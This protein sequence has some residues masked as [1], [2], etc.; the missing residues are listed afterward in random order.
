MINM[1]W[2]WIGLI[3]SIASLILLII[4]WWPER[5]NQWNKVVLSLG[6]IIIIIP[7]AVLYFSVK[8]QLNLKN[9]LKFAEDKLNYAEIAKQNYLGVTDTVGNGLTEESFQSKT[10]GPFVSV[11][12]DHVPAWRCSDSA[13]EA[14]DK[15]IREVPK[16][17]FTYYYRGTCERANNLPGWEDDINTAKNILSITVTISFHHP[18]HD[19]FLGMINSKEYPK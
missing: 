11:N 8:G 4:Q 7:L 12:T 10:I 1:L 16:F 19:D 14:Y 18:N 17:P 2:F 5:K 15:V 3:S 6:I 13:M 9:K